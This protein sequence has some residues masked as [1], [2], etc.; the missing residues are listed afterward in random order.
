MAFMWVF[1]FNQWLLYIESIRLT[2]QRNRLARHFWRDRL[3]RLRFTCANIFEIEHTT[4]QKWTK[5]EKKNDSLLLFFFFF[6]FIRFS[7]Q[8]ESWNANIKKKK[9]FYL[10]ERPSMWKYFFSLLSVFW[11]HSLLRTQN[12][13]KQKKEKK[14]K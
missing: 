12:T 8:F 13:I 10:R 5:E 14:T 4:T 11:L 9:F 3:F 6:Y 1:I 7:I 2:N